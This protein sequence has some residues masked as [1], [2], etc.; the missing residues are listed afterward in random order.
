MGYVFGDFLVR[1]Q[2]DKLVMAAAWSGKDLPA[3][4]ATLDWAAARRIPVILIGPIILYEESLPRLLAFSVRNDD[5]GMVDRHRLYLT[6]L[7]EQL[8]ALARQKGA[9]YI[10]LHQALCPEGACAV[11]AAPDIPLQFDIGHLTQEGSVFVAE[12]IKALGGLP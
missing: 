10:S 1:H 3:V 12:R 4:A 11:L 8:R 6:A 9:E 7:D 5:P 2:V